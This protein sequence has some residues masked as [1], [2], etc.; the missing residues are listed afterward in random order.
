MTTSGCFVSAAGQKDVRECS[1]HHR[2]ECAQVKLFC[3][4]HLTLKWYHRVNSGVFRT[5]PSA[6]LIERKTDREKERT[7]SVVSENKVM[8]SQIK[9]LH[10][11]PT[12]IQVP[13]PKHP[14]YP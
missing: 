13:F 10:Y 9:I 2:V 4:K 1:G 3:S 6:K 7:R 8:S 11:C 5:A 12:A 14:L